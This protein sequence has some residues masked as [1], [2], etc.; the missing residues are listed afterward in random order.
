[1]S[2]SGRADEH[3]DEQRVDVHRTSISGRAQ[4]ALD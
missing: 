1:M 4:Q 2:S 3:P